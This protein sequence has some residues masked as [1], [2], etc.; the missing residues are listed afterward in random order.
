MC[1]Q[2]ADKGMK[3]HVHGLAAI[4][5]LATAKQMGSVVYVLQVRDGEQMRMAGIPMSTPT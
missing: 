1:G 3:I 5:N 4:S 2:S